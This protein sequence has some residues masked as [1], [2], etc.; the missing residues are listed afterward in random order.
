M[1]LV[2]QLGLRSVYTWKEV[3][4]FLGMTRRQVK[5]LVESGQ[6]V[7]AHKGR[8]GFTQVHL[9]QFLTRLNAG[10]AS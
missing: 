5:H 4:D 7:K 6:L 8:F 9:N 2:P 10:K 3:C 1:N